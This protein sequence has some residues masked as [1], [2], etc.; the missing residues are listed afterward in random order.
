MEDVSAIDEAGLARLVDAFYNRVRTD[1]QL[2][3]IFSGAIS[4]WPQHIEKL[5]D[6]W[7]SV[8]LGTGR[9]KGRPVPTHLKHR[10][11]IT[12]TMFE[13][14]LALWQQTTDE[15]LPASAAAALQSKAARIAESLQLAMF[16]QLRT[17][18]GVDRSGC[19]G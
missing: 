5:T 16:F 12:T 2:G 4:D 6:F 17:E 13:R 9:Y 15:L 3:P 19:R 10:D 18:P 7:S 11:A 14:W 8:M 1:P